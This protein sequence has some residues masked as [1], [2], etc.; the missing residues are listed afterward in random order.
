MTPE[1]I[2][3]WGFVTGILCVCGICV[4]F[5]LLYLILRGYFDDLFDDFDI[6]D[7]FYDFD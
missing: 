7:F 5:W 3:I 2:Y 1:E 6:D 4:V